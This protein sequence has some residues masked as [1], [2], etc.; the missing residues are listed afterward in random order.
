M[1]MEDM[2]GQREVTMKEQR[3]V[4]MKGQR[5]VMEKEVAERKKIGRGRG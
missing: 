3:E 5:E 4:M 2:K 1:E